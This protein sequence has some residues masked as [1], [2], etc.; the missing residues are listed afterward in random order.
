MR[1]TSNKPTLAP[2]QPM[3]LPRPRSARFAPLGPAAAAAR[4][5]PSTTRSRVG[6]LLQAKPG[7]GKLAVLRAVQQRHD[8]AGRL[9]V[10]DAA[11]AAEH[12]WLVQARRELL[13][14]HGT[15]APQRAD[16]ATGWVPGELNALSRA[17]AEAPVGRTG[18]QGP[19]RVVVTLSSRKRSDAGP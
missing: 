18:K 4:W 3:F 12:D 2:K 17:A 13:E 19:V 15:V 6:S 7:V 11:D 9:S 10:L 1:R 8:P 14:S 5:R 16:T